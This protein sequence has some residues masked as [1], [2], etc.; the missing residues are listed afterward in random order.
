MKKTITQ[1][2]SLMILSVFFLKSTAQITITSDFNPEIGDAFTVSNCDPTGFDPGDGGENVTWDFSDVVQTLVLNYYIAEPSEGLDSEFFPAADFVWI[3]EELDLHNYYI[4]DDDS[5]AHIG[6][7]IGYEGEAFFRTVYEDFDDFIHFPLNYDDQYTYS[8]TFELFSLGMSIGSGMR[9]SDTH[10][11]GYGTIITPYGTYEDCLRV[12]IESLEDSFITTQYV[13]LI[14][15]TFMPVF[16]YQTSTDPKEDDYMEYT[17]IDLDPVGVDDLVANSVS[18]SASSEDGKIRLLN[19]G[20]FSTTSAR[21]SLFDLNGR[22]LES[23]S[24]ENIRKGSSIEWET[25]VSNGLYVISVSDERTVW[26]GPLL[27]H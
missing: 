5:I 2:L 23:S 10:V 16:Q 26:S 8:S 6:G 19:H 9:T 3:L 4:A 24:W 7:V 17:H 18:F 15:D 12:V 13:W 25:T 14:A 22:L 27:K 21:V 1:Y 20:D 11:D